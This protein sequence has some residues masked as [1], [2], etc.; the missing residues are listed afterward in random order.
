MSG[1]R[2]KRRRTPWIRFKRFLRRRARPFA[3]KFFA[4]NAGTPPPPQIQEEDDAM[5]IGLEP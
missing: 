4:K 1:K 2:A 5:E 3:Q